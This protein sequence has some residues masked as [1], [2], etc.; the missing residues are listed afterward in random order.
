M[1]KGIKTLGYSK[2]L[3]W[4]SQGFVHKKGCVYLTHP[5]LK[6]IFL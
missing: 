4:E 5:F 3:T 6:K 1:L 2:A